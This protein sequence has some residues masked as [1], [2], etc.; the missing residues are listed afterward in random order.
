MLQL[1]SQ[2]SKLG[3]IILSLFAGLVSQEF[4]RERR[5]GG[6][7]LVFPLV[8]CVSD[9]KNALDEEK[10]KK[11]QVLLIKTNNWA[12]LLIFLVPPFPF[13]ITIFSFEKLRRG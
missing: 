8:L 13:T 5:W 6:M 11:N 1:I 3:I 12:Y 4:K 2:G 10:G 9:L 7:G